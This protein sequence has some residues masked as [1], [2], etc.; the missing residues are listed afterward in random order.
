MG[1]TEKIRKNEEIKAWPGKFPVQYLYTYGI[2][3]EKF[4]ERIKE[5]GKFVGTKCKK[6]N[7]VYTPPKIYCEKCFEEL[8]NYVNVKDTGIIQTFTILNYDAEGNKL[9]NSQI[10]AQIKL[11]NSEGGLIHYV[12]GE[13]DTIK[14]G[15]RVK[16]KFK[17]KNERVGD[18]F[19]V[20]YFEV[21]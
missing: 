12:K 7:I 20:E 18:I 2:A 11:D 9:K 13:Q 10:I 21:I 14:I 5:E 1:I 19:D 15:R 16:A 3:G 6:C 4:F 8:K 17:D